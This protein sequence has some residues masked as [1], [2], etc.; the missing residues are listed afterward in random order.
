MLTFRPGKVGTWSVAL[1][2]SGK[3]GGYRRVAT[4]LSLSEATELALFLRN[5]ENRRAYRGMAKPPVATNV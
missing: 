3:K 4:D 2:R 1:R 5:K